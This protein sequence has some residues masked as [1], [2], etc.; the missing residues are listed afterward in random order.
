MTGDDAPCSVYVGRPIFEG[1]PFDAGSDEKMR[2]KSFEDY[3]VRYSKKRKE[4][5]EKAQDMSSRQMFEAGLLKAVHYTAA[6][7]SS[8]FMNGMKKFH[9]KF[10]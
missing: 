10:H 8:V 4:I 9:L 6:A 5:D 1:L 7:C 3:A 2:G